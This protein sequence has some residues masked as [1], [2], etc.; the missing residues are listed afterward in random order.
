MLTNRFIFHFIAALT[1]PLSGNSQ[2]YT[3]ELNNPKIKVKPAADIQAYSFS[4]ADIKLLP[5]SPFY[6]AMEKD[7]AY[8]LKIEPSRLLHRFH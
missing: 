5:G 7:A 2:S 3:P 6:N 8:L 4:L 1:L